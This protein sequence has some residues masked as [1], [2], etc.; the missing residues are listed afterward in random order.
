MLAIA[1]V[2]INI[3][4]GF[5]TAVGVTIVVAICYSLGVPVPVAAIAL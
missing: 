1:W 2:T 4:K 3:D 5:A